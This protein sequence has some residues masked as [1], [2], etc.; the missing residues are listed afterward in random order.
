MI[1]FR[2]QVCTNVQETGDTECDYQNRSEKQ[3]KNR[4][5]ET[6]NGLQKRNIYSVI[7]KYIF[8]NSI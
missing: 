8:F 6:K 1:P 7:K 2:F 5:R 3:E 4:Y